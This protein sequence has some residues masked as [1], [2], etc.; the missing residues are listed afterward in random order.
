[1]TQIP[2][3]LFYLI[4]FVIGKIPSEKKNDNARKDKLT[5]LL[6]LSSVFWSI[7]QKNSYLITTFE[8]N[9]AAEAIL[10]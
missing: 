2:F 7:A 5:Q 4:A 8:S 6:L 3:G 10:K 9:A 1:M